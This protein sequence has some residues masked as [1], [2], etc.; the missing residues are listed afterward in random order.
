MGNNE[1]IDYRGGFCDRVFAKE[2]IA[3][4]EAL[5]SKLHNIQKAL[6]W[7]NI[8]AT[9][10]AKY[11]FLYN[12]FAQYLFHD[13]FLIDPRK[14]IKY[15]EHK[16]ELNSGTEAYY[17][18]FRNL[19]F[20]N[21][22]YSKSEWFVKR[23]HRKQD[24]LLSGYVFLPQKVRDSV[25]N[26]VILDCGAYDY[27]GA[28]MFSY[29]GFTVYG[30]EP[31]SSAY[32]IASHRLS[33]KGISGV[34]CIKKAVCREKN[35]KLEFI[36]LGL[37]SRLAT[38]SIKADN[39]NAKLE[40]VDAVSIDEFVNSN[41]INKVD[42]IKLNIEGMELN[43]FY[44]AF[45][46]IKRDKPVILLS[47]HR[48]SDMLS[49]FDELSVLGYKFMFRHLISDSISSYAIDDLR[50]SEFVLICWHE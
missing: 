6:S 7:D 45:N 27:S 3:V 5:L 50:M 32:N 19:D 4:H 13:F 24:K 8:S 10:F 29:L 18:S 26:G 1:M 41:G 28:L 40:A 25:K 35:T 2:Y 11:T 39:P 17:N 30:F 21:D 9:E 20:V 12:E 43:A 22:A 47:H 42:V 44:G 37:D 48:V 33:E 23:I 14:F 36:D 15:V 16:F 46:T 31:M 49:I 38:D 34:H